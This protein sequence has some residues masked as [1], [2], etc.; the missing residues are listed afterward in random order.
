M[1]MFDLEEDVVISLKPANDS[2]NQSDS[3]VPEKSINWTEVYA[4][5]PLDGSTQDKERRKAM[6]RQFDSNGNGHLS[7][8]EVEKGI[9]DVLAIDDAVFDAKPAITRAFN[10]AK[11]ATHG[12]SQ[13]GADKVELAE[14]RVFLS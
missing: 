10:S 12:L 3:Q 11:D 4:K 14:L 9:R 5:L 1:K 8:A 2:I 6:F 7:L 13:V